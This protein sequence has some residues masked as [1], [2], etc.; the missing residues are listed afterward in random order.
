MCAE[1]LTHDLVSL[2]G[3]RKTIIVPEGVRE[4]F[5]DDKLGVYAGA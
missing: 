3:L 2:A 1:E 4:R 5:K